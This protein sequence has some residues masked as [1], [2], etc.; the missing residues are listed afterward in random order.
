M[1]KF[2]GHTE[3]PHLVS[4]MQNELILS[5]ENKEKY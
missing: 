2:S 4:N 5:D 1:R 3:F